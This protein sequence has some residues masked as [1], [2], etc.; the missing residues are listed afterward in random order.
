M[1]PV[2]KYGLWQSDEDLCKVC[3]Y[4]MVCPDNRHLN[5]I[6]FCGTFKHVQEERKGNENTTPS[7]PT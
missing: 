6:H 7:G 1:Q 2:L 4:K 3:L 5:N